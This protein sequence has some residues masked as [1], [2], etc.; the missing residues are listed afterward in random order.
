M[1]TSPDKESLKNSLSKLVPKLNLDFKD[2]KSRVPNL[3]ISSLKHMNKLAQNFGDM[4]SP[5]Y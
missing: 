2:V 4:M 3:P 1:Q 5:I